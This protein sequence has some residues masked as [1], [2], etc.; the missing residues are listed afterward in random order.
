MVHSTRPWASANGHQT[1]ACHPKSRH[2]PEIPTAGD[3]EGSSG[4][5]VEKTGKL[6]CSYKKRER[7]GVLFI[8]F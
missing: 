2:W 8:L 4:A 1:V 6:A 5:L 3:F 7:I